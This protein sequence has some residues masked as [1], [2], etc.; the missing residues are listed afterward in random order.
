MELLLTTE[1]RKSMEVR[2]KASRTS[3]KLS[4]TSADTAPARERMNE[5]RSSV[6]RSWGPPPDASHV[7]FDTQT[8]STFGDALVG[9]GCK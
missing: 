4:L 3:L 6:A 9:L 7:A 1:I 5:G 8:L 2:E